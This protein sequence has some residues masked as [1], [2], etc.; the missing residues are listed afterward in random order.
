MKRGWGRMMKKPISI[1]SGTEGEVM[2]LR[3]HISPAPSVGQIRL[4]PSNV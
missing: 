2:V 1:K 4:K 3:P